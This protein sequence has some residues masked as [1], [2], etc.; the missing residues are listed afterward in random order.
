MKNKCSFEAVGGNSCTINHSF[1]DDDDDGRSALAYSMRES[2]AND[3]QEKIAIEQEN[4][5][6]GEREIID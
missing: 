3:D 2:R 5:K 4:E 6:E 1:V